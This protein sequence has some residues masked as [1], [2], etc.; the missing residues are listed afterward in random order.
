MSTYTLA[1]LREGEWGRVRGIQTEEGMCRRL[2]ELGLVEGTRVCCL[3]QAPAGDPVAYDIRG[4]V[5]A[6]RR[7]DAAGVLLDGPAGD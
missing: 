5:I 2:M 1:S 4:A 3:Q 6:L 7:R